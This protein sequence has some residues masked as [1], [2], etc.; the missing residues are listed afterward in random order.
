[1]IKLKTLSI[2]TFSLMA[3]LGAA[4]PASADVNTNFRKSYSGGAGGDSKFGAGYR[5]DYGFA[6]SKNGG[7]A[8]LS[9]DAGTT[10]WVKLFNKT[11][12][13]VTLKANATGAL[14]TTGTQ[15]SASLAYETFLVGIKV[16][17]A[18]GSVAGGKFAN[19]TIIS[20]SQKLLPKANIDLVRIGPAV[21][22]LE[23]W[24]SAT[25]YVKINGT[26]WC[27]SISAELRPGANITAVANFRADAVIAAAGL[28]GTLTLM[29]VS[30]PA[31]AS[32][33][34]SWKKESDFFSNGS[35]C[36]WTA[37]TS[38]NAKVEIVPVSGKF[39]PWVRVGLPCTDIF[40]I[41]PGKGICLNKEWSHTLWSASAG[42]SSFALA[43]AA[44]TPFIGTSTTSC[45]A[46]PPAVPNR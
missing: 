39:E 5:L 16:P 46:N 4:R 26:A 45:P 23:A 31:T 40:G 12:D 42:K 3:T 18:S 19:K 41:L 17:T 24:A 29:D 1:M 32:I 9:A 30:V 27:N 6:A 37:G 38:A 11:F 20:R 36:S 35:F 15:C 10:G 44:Y 7:N 21:L 13:A 22:G 14:N 25:E 8:K 2:A 33:G 34:W 28:R 43:S